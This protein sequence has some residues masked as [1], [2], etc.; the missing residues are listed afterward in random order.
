[1]SEHAEHHTTAL[2]AP[3]LSLRGISHTFGPREVLANVALD[4]TAQQ[5]VALIGPSGCGKTTLMH[6]CAGLL[7]VQ[8]GQIHNTFARSALMFQQPLLLPWLSVAD[9]IALSLHAHPLSRAQQHAR[10]AHMGASLGLDALALRQFPHQ[11]SGGMQSRAALARALVAEPDLLLLDEPFAALDIGLKAHMHALVQRRRR[12]R[13]MAALLITHDVAE[14]VTLADTIFVMAAQPGRMVWRLDIPAHIQRTPQWTLQQT[15]ALLAQ[16][17]VRQAFGLPDLPT[18][19][20]QAACAPI[21]PGQPL[22]S[23]TPLP[24][25]R[26]C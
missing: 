3:H 8:T 24:S 23:T 7:S 11:L 21:H 25:E 13:P 15:A 1:M 2:P 16:P 18:A 14:A 20:E 17:L 10:A 9:N 5:C 22:H 19:A 12:E 6:L 4:V 26:G